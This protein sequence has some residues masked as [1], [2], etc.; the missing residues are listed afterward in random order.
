MAQKTEFIDPYEVTKWYNENTDLGIVLDIPASGV[1]EDILKRSAKVQRAN[2]KVMLAEKEKHVELINVVHGNNIDAYKKFF[3]IVHDDEVNRLCMA[4]AYSG[5]AVNA[6]GDML[7]MFMDKDVMKHYKHYHILGVYNVSVIPLYIWLANHSMKDKLI[8]SDASSYLYSALGH[9]VY[10]QRTPL[11][12]PEPLAFGYD[13]GVRHSNPHRQLSCCC[14]VCKTVK[15]SDIFGMLSGGTLSFVLAHHNIYEN[16][17]YA[18]MMDDYA[19]QLPPAEYREMMRKQLESHNSRDATLQA[20]DFIQ[21]AETDGIKAARSRYAYYFT[22]NRSFQKVRLDDEL[23]S[24][25]KT[26]EGDEAVSDLNQDEQQYRQLID[27]VLTDY[28]KLHKGTDEEKAAVRKRHAKK[29]NTVRVRKTFGSEGARFNSTNNARGK[30]AL[31]QLLKKQARKQEKQKKADIIISKQRLE[32]SAKAERKAIRLGKLR[33]LRIAKG[34]DPDKP[35]R[36]VKKAIKHA[37]TTTSK[38]AA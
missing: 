11:H 7:S 5:H 20:F 32:K 19:R 36:P 28:E 15:Y 8:T 22:D 37:L 12:P 14:P 30:R 1:G 38:A 33:E 31:K 4:N 3:D 2:T 10:L 9:H 13:S 34:F 16:C 6:V 35:M 29:K 17:R 27:R 18:A 26:Y 21:K 25:L 24:V 23:K